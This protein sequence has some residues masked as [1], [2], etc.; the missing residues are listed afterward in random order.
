MQVEGKYTFRVTIRVHTGF[1]KFLNGLEWYRVELGSSGASP[2]PKTQKNELNLEMAYRGAYNRRPGAYLAYSTPVGADCTPLPQF[3]W[4]CLLFDA[5]LACTC[6]MDCLMKLIY[7]TNFLYVVG[8]RWSLQL[9]AGM[10]DCA[11]HEPNTNRLMSRMTEVNTGD[12]DDS[13]PYSRTW[14][15]R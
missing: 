11:K 14:I 2:D 8:V 15:F 9:D 5:I 12:R 3:W 7:N 6:N 13:N 10:N 4:F 1:G